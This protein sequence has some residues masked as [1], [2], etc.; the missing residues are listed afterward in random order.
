MAITTDASGMPRG[1]LLAL[2]SASGLAVCTA[3]SVVSR[4]QLDHQ[5]DMDVDGGPVHASLPLPDAPSPSPTEFPP[6]PRVRV[7][8]A[9]LGKI[10]QWIAT[11]TTAKMYVH[12]GLSA[13]WLRTESPHLS[14]QLHHTIHSCAVQAHRFRWSHSNPTHLVP[15]CGVHGNVRPLRQVSDSRFDTFGMQVLRPACSARRKFADNPSDQLY[16]NGGGEF[17]SRAGSVSVWH[18]STSLAFSR[19]RMFVVSLFSQ[20]QSRVPGLFARQ[21]CS[22]PWCIQCHLQK[23]SGTRLM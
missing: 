6:H 7:T 4:V 5:L 15:S 12:L 11:D 9:Q 2:L 21:T 22:F 18:S 8:D 16:T 17:A 19:S 13:P 1:V 3:N 14:P 10:K 20:L 23:S